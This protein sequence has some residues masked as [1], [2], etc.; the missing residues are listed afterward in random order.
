[1]SNISAWLDTEEGYFAMFCRQFS[2]SLF[3]FQICGGTFK[4]SERRKYYFK[5]GGG[6]IT[7]SNKPIDFKTSHMH[8]TLDR[9]SGTDFQMFFLPRK[10]IKVMMLQA[11]SVWWGLFSC[12]PEKQQQYIPIYPQ[13]KNLSLSVILFENGRKCFRGNWTFVNIINT[14][15]F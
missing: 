5:T 10:E 6:R 1:M 12:M 11:L 7:F 15:F 3:P 8:P 4:E 14:A 13:H 2:A 9:F